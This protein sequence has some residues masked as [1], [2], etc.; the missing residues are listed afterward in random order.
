M[1]RPPEERQALADL[2]ALSELA[3]YL[4]NAERVV[5]AELDGLQAGG[6]TPEVGINIQFSVAE[7]NRYESEHGAGA[8]GAAF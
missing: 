7:V 1:Q 8:A 2:A 4:D 5:Q 6:M 3:A